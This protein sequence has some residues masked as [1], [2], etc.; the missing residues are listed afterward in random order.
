MAR[1]RGR[2]FLVGAGPGDPGL[3]TVKGLKLLRQAD[4]VVHDRLIPHELLDEVKPDTHIIDVGKYPGRPR[5]SQDEINALLIEQ[6]RHGSLVVRLKGGDPLL[7]GRGWEEF[8]ACLQAGVA[9]E[10]VP[11][12]TSA[13]AVPASANIPVTLRKVSR[14]VAVVTAQ[15]ED[16]RGAD[17]LNYDALAGM[18]T[19]V[20]LMGLANLRVVVERLVA[21]GRDPHT[22]AACIERGTMPQQRVVTGNLETIANLADEAQLVSPTTTVIGEVVRQAALCPTSLDQ[23]S[24]LNQTP[25]PLPRSASPRAASA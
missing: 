22:P 14:A 8:V 12:V 20:V 18:E 3:I 9:C 2:V 10:I 15:S 5:H 24:I 17:G 7:F 16:G 23:T 1:Q 11:G 19:I 13:L 6:A 21:A 25:H 4:V